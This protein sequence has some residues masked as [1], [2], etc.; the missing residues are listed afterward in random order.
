MQINYHILFPKAESNITDTTVSFT[1]NRIRSRL[2]SVLYFKLHLYN[3]Y[4]EEI[5]YD[6]G[7]VKVVEEGSNDVAYTSPRSAIGN[8]TDEN[9]KPMFD[10]YTESFLLE[11]ALIEATAYFQIELIT[12]GV[13]SENPLY[14]AQ[15][16]FKNGEFDPTIGYHDPSE[17]IRSHLIGLPNNLYAN[18]Y[19][20]QGNYLQVIRPNKESFHTDK[21]DGAEMTVLA[22]H[23]ADD[24]GVDDDISVYLELMNQTEQ[25][26]NVLR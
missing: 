26:I 21:L 15:V 18:L 13:D 12:I 7:E 3:M 11:S 20:I 1:I 24:T 6:D 25:T 23:F 16:M 4:N 22:P 10:C 8:P 19:D 9:G 2:P 14:F 5:Y 17:Y